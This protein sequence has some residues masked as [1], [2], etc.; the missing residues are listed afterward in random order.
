MKHRMTVKRPNYLAKAVAVTAMPLASLGIAPTAS[1]A[2]SAITATTAGTKAVGATTY[3]WGTATGAAAGTT[4]CDDVLLTTGWS[5]SQCSTTDATGYYQ[6]PLTYGSKTAGTYTY[7]V[8][9]EGVYSPNVTL[10]R[11]SGTSSPS[12][13]TTV[14]MHTT[15]SS[16]NVRTSASTSSAVA[17]ILPANTTVTGT[18]TNGWLKIASP[19]AYAGK[20][21]STSV[22]AS[23]AATSSA[24]KPTTPLDYVK[25]RATNGITLKAG[26]NG[27]KVYA[28]RKALGLP[29]GPLQTTMDAAAVSAVKSFQTKKAL[30]ATGEVDPQTFYALMDA[31]GQPYLFTMDSWVQPA[32]VSATAPRSERVA[33]LIKYA[34]DRLG[35]AYVWGGTGTSD[36]TIGFDCSGLLLQAVRAAGYAPKNVSNWK[37]IEPVSMLSNAMWLDAEFPKGN[38]SSPQPGD[39]VYYG[40][41]NNVVHH[42]ALYIGN[43]TVISA[44]N[45]APSGIRT[46]K[47]SGYNFGWSK[48]VGINRMP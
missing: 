12:T 16:T 23:G 41:S 30:P 32:L 40:G 17:S 21:I 15:Y 35:M 14:T 46:N 11:T 36:G 13:S 22:L 37:D 42:V 1:A 38:V 2:T 44:A 10:T 6:I 26:Y 8:V 43:D 45:D 9:A 29:N 27:V 5:R 25:G 48:K 28:V 18:V 7:R 3:V 39:L 47:Y 31:S 24:P 34:Q 19:S 20:Y 4:I 33:T